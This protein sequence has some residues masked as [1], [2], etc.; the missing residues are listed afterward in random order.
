MVVKSPDMTP[1]SQGTTGM[2]LCDFTIIVNWCF[3]TFSMDF[4]A[5]NIG[6][7]SI[8]AALTTLHEIFQLRQILIIIF[9]YNVWLS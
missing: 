4:T 1:S 5:R 8:A 3:I 7:A 9:E 2:S 6:V